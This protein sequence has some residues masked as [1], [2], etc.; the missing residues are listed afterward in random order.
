MPA[1]LF[2]AVWFA[3]QFVHGVAELLLPAASTYVAWWAHIGGF[4]AGLAFGSPLMRSNPNRQRYY[5]DEGV[6]GFT[7]SGRP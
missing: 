3:M 4:L 5:A 1:V 6:L 7:P 2:V